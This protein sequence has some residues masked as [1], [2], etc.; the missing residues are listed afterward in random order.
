MVKVVQREDGWWTVLDAKGLALALGLTREE[1][2][3]MAS[4]LNRKG[5]DEQRR[6]EDENE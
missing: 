1:A 2:E 3:R 5:R 4:R 6:H